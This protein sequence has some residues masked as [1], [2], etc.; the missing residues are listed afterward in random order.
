MWVLS[1]AQAVTDWQNFI[2]AD[3]GFSFLSDQA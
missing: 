1:S 2:Y 3:D